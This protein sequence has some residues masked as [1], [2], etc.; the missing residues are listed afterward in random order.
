MSLGLTKGDE[1]A[2]HVTQSVILNLVLNLFQYCFRISN[3]RDS[4]TSSE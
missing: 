1:N 4:E 3:V 2:N